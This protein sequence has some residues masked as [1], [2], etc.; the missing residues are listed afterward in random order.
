MVE[1]TGEQTTVQAYWTGTDVLSAGTYLVSIFADGH[2]IG[3]GRFN[4]EE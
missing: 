2:L 4:M 1:Y 3:S